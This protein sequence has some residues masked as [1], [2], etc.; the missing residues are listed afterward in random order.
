MTRL[1]S[2]FLAMALYIDIDTVT[3][4]AGKCG[5]E[6]A[7]RAY[8]LLQAWRGTKHGR[9]AVWHAAQVLRAARSTRPYELRGAEAYMTFHAVMVLWTYGML[10]LD[11]A[12]HS[13]CNTP[14]PQPRTSSAQHAAGESGAESAVFLDGPMSDA[15]EAY[16]HLG[17]GRPCLRRRKGATTESSG[18]EACDLQNPPSIMQ[19]GVEVLRANCPGDAPHD[20]PQMLRSLCDVMDG[21]GR[22]K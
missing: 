21:L 20:M 5:E 15:T 12:K 10:Y 1:F 6:E 9:A 17:R 18:Q 16:V 2:E 7:H 11:S 3:R 13:R 8:Q 22:L 19:A 4:F 14:A